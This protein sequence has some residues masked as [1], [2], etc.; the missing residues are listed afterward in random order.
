MR[1]CRH[2][3]LPVPLLGH[4]CIT[5][6]PWLR[7]L[8]SGHPGRWECLRPGRGGVPCTHN[9]DLLL[10]GPE[11]A[12]LRTP[13][14]VCERLGRNSSLKGFPQ[15]D[16]PPREVKGWWAAESTPALRRPACHTGRS[17]FPRSR[18]QVPVPA[19]GLRL[20]VGRAHRTAADLQTPGACLTPHP[21]PAPTCACASGVAPLD[22]QEQRPVSGRGGRCADPAPRGLQVLAAPP[23]LAHSPQSCGWTCGRW[24]RRST[25]SCTA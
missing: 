12:M 9:W 22:L 11:L 3:L 17:C 13:R 10:L 15:Y 21:T 16:S 6:C 1:S 23:R 18:P 20:P 24:C 7:R 19:S 5:A 2:R 8:P 25:V 14:P 4:P